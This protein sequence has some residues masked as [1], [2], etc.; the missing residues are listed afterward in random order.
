MGKSG[1]KLS[2]NMRGAAWMLLS[3]ASFTIMAVCIKLLAEQEYSEG[4]MLFFRAAVGIIL[5]APITMRSGLSV[6]RTPRP[7]NMA[8]RVGASALGVLLSYYA[9]ANMPLATAQSLSFARALFVVLL[10]MLLLRERVGIWRQSALAAGFVGI[11]VMLRPTEMQ[12]NLAAFAALASAASLAYSI[13]TIKDLTRDHSTLSLVLWMNAGTTVL[14]LPFAFFGWRTPGLWDAGV[15]VLLAVSGVV[16]QSAFTRGLATGDASF[17][18]LM[19]YVRLPMT[20]L[21]GYILFQ[22]RVD[23]WTVLGA[24]IVIVSTVFIT[25]REAYLD[26]RRAPPPPG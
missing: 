2:G 10:A 22:E 25:L 8:R 26:K 18:T 13:V 6:W 14:A 19:D 3:A 5:L 17:V 7:W 4:Q 20:A 16:A 23:V 12:F 9:F 24:M 21:A 11:M 1:A 15:F